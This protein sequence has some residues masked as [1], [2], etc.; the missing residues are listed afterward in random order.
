MDEKKKKR[1]R[2]TKLT[3]ELIEDIAANLAKGLNNADAVKLAGASETSFYRWLERAEKA[4]S[5]IFWEFGEKITR[6]RVDR[7]ATLIKRIEVASRDD[8]RA[9]MAL[10]ERQYPDEFAQRKMIEHDGKI[11]G[12]GASELRVVFVDTEKGE[13]E[14]GDEG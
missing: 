2:R 3:P 6:A 1:G 7:K 8:W 13:G 9:A 12:G 10:L 4:K 11:E 14:D 5:G